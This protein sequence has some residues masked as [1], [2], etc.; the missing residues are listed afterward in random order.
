LI[1]LQAGF[2]CLTFFQACAGEFPF[3]AIVEKKNDFFVDEEDAFDGD[4]PQSIFEH[5][6]ALTS[7]S[8]VFI[9]SGA[10]SARSGQGLNPGCRRRGSFS[11]WHALPSFH[12]PLCFVVATCQQEMYQRSNWI[13]C[14][15]MAIVPKGHCRALPR[16]GYIEQPGAFALGKVVCKRRPESGTQCWARR[17][18]NTRTDERRASA[19]RADFALRM[20]QG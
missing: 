12:Q 20:T 19:A 11:R 14:C 7:R 4:R 8:S 18:N 15:G 9:P 17:W 10:L 16:S 1:S 6:Q 13:G 5:E 3:I 2:G